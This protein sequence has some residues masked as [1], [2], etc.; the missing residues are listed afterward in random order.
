VKFSSY[1]GRKTTTTKKGSIKIL[2]ACFSNKSLAN[3][4]LRKIKEAGL[5]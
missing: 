3:Y 1:C 4:V 5:H 2:K